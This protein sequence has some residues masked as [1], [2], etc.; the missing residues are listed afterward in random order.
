MMLISFEGKDLLDDSLGWKMPRKLREDLAN[1]NNKWLIYIN[2]PFGSEG[3]RVKKGTDKGKN[4]SISKVKS[5]M[6]EDKLKNPSRELIGQFFYRLYKEIPSFTLSTF[7]T[8]K[9]LSD[10]SFIPFYDYL[11]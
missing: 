11:K 4:I 2:P 1:K 9:Y 8:L 3:G 10:E 5:R 6:I 7:S